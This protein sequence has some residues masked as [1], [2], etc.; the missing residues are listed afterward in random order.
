MKIKPL[1][2]LKL[3]CSLFYKTPTGL[4]V[5]Y[6][7]A[8]KKPLKM[9]AN[10]LCLLLIFLLPAAFSVPAFAQKA[11]MVAGTVKDSHGEPLIGVAVRVKGTNNGTSTNIDGKYQLSVADKNAT[12]V[13]TYIGFVTAEQPL[14]GKIVLNIA[15]K[16]EAKS[17][18]EVVILGYGQ[19]K[20]KDLTGSVGTVDMGDLNKA[21][22]KSFD[23]AL[24]GRV[25]G[26]QV[27]SPDGQPGASPAIVIRGGNSVTQDN[28]PLYVID[29]FPIEGYNNNALDP[30]DIE[31]I[32][33]LKDASSTA[34]YGARG[35]NGVIIITTK[36]GKSG[37][38]VVTYSTYYGIQNNTGTVKVMDPYNYVKYQLEIDSVTNS[39]LYNIYN[40]T[41]NP[42]GTQSLESYRDAPA[43]DWQKQI[44]RKALMQNHSLAIRG[45]NKDTKYTISGSFLGQD[46]TVIASGFK[47]YQ[48]RFTL[49]QNVT[50]KL[51]V[52]INSNY[53]YLITN[54][55]QVGGV[56]STNDA[57]LISTWRYRP[58]AGP[59]EDLN[60]LLTAA[61]DLD[62]VSSTN[63][64]WNPVLTLNNELRNRYQTLI[65]TNAYLDYSFIPELRLRITG[66][67]NSSHLEAD[68]F[69]TSNSRLGSPTSTLGQGGPNG[70]VTYGDITNLVNENTLTYNKVFARKHA[71]N[72]LVGFTMGQN[73]TS[74]SG[75]GAIL[76]P[77]E[78][79]GVNGL[80]QGQPFSITSSKSTNT[81]VSFLSR[82][83]YNYDSK[84][85]ATASFRTD[86]SSKFLDGNI[87]GYFPSGSLAWRFSQEN[88]AKPLKFLSDGK[89]RASYGITG[90][91]RVNDQA[92]Y[93]LLGQGGAA[94][95]YTPGN[96]YI[97]GAY[98]LN[99]ANPNLKWE[100]TAEADLGID[101]SLLNQ[102][103]TF[104]ADVYNKKTT[105]LLLNASLPGVTG[106]ASAFQNVGSVQNRGLEFA[107]STA[108]ITN[109]DFTWNTS[110]NISFNR[111][112]VLSLTSGQSYLNT[113]VKFSG[114]NFVAASPA[115][116]AQVGQPVSMFYGLVSDGVYQTSDYNQ[117]SPGVY[118]LKPGIP[119]YGSTV[120]KTPGAWKFKDLNG[121]GVIDVNDLTTIGNPNPKFI[122]GF[123]NNFTYKGFDL[124]V[125]LQYSY[126]NQ[127]M[128]VNRLLMEGGAG[129]SVT[130]GANQFASY[131]DR[132][133]PDN[134]SNTYARAGAG[135]ASPAYYASRDVEDGSFIRLKTVN[136][137]YTFKTAWV[138]KANL[139]A[140]RLYAS[141]QNL[142][143]LTKYSGLDP[144]V[145]SYPS[146][147]TTGMDYSGY[148]RAKVI[149][150]GL[151][152]T[153]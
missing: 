130:V 131:A 36:R 104:T 136:L 63:Y 16:D 41:T 115:F 106:Y 98:P 95:A 90:N 46:G 7:E 51:K 39:V 59:N 29:G 117:T 24:A 121:D 30:A 102:R 108:N 47:R 61:Q 71:L 54:G 25:A 23:D 112:K 3:V 81:L 132:W 134:P 151:N 150:L 5:K 56:S 32:E 114:A 110:F 105:N 37:P 67:I 152:L 87:W 69:N 133:E 76:V 14:G 62:V 13:F 42:T 33:V 113:I 120:L 80:S 77:N 101:L 141:A 82:V 144:E 70:S 48:G 31:S 57:L 96:V 88:F 11:I 107:L 20:R 45:G 129:V 143:T 6:F 58:L 15:L 35:A 92:A 72:V 34:I 116:I 85:L 109:K 94:G 55:T 53:S 18:N 97:S 146:A 27:T 89:I 74:T 124:N 111:T 153:F 21:P 83:N 100:N 28:S 138:K 84:Y 68:Q 86:G 135:G 26:V 78:S 119:T 49:D 43:I 126:G 103:I 128:N 4:L 44:F 142:Y 17:L 118:V 19:A 123:S 93:A 12:L 52:G 79:L 38:P 73:T 60:S 50:D 75:G 22:V 91:N 147:L 127:I 137:G 64:Q 139:A 40:P 145:N 65:T 140:L 99:L 1:L 2:K 125:F 148:P 122:G 10:A 8:Y 66:G 9:Q 149:T